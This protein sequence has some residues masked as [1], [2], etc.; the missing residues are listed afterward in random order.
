MFLNFSL[1]IVRENCVNF[2]G[3]NLLWL[4]PQ[5]LA[6]STDIK[7]KKLTFFSIKTT[8]LKLWETVF[9]HGQK[10]LKIDMPYWG[11]IIPQLCP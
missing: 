9:S 8:Q 4:Q 7:K 6:A 3:P 1:W 11:V 10:L 5:G 2:C